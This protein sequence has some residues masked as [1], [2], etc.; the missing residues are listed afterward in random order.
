MKPEVFEFRT[1]RNFVRL[2]LDATAEFRALLA[3]LHNDGLR[4]SGAAIR[5]TLAAVAKHQNIASDW[6][7]AEIHRLPGQTDIHTL[8]LGD[9]VASE[10]ESHLQRLINDAEF[11]RLI[12]S[13]PKS[14]QDACADG[15]TKIR[16]DLDDDLVEFRAG[17]LPREPQRGAAVSKT[18][19]NNLSVQG[20]LSGVVQQGGA[21]SSQSA[22]LTI[23]VAKVGNALE[24]LAAS[25]D[26]LA[27]LALK[28]ELRAEIDTIRPQ[29]RKGS[30]NWE[31]VRT[32]SSAIKALTLGVSGNLLT[33][34]VTAL[35]ASVGLA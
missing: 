2:L 26:D 18:T 22:N 16:S 28:E 34:Y 8:V 13:M 12:A 21:G 5:L 19:N 30:P 29:L 32:A 17:Y 24:Q 9:F 1:R 20:N 25:I 35:L 6:V 7:F 4:N 11:G 3:R 14:A 33:P 27:D 10:L 31:I 23:D 15:L